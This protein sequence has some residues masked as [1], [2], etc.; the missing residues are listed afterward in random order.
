VADI[1]DPDRLLRKLR[2]FSPLR[3][4]LLATP[5]TLQGALSAYFGAPVTVKVVEQRERADGR[6]DREVELV[7][8]ERGFAAC[9]AVTEI[10]VNDESI[11]ELVRDRHMGLG[12]IIELFRRRASFDLE[13]AGE[14]H[15]RF[16]RRYRLA[17]DGFTFRIT[18]TFPTAQYSDDH[19]EDA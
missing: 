16:W 2:G 5:G 4:V 9:H 1:L 17:G 18:E 7:C 13:E 6:I 14:D 3:R 10:E 12:Q 8:E 19:S 11:K 15:D